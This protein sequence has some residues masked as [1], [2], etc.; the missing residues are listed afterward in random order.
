MKWVREHLQ[1]DGTET[2]STEDLLAFTLMGGREQKQAVGVVQKLLDRYGIRWLRNASVDELHHTAG[3]TVAQASRMKAV[4]ELTSRFAMMES[5]AAR[6][7]IRC[8]EDAAMLLR[9]LMAHLDHEE[10][11]VLVLDAKNYVVANILLYIGTVDTTS[12]R[13][14]EIFRPAVVRNCPK[15]IAAHNHPSSDPGASPEDLA[16]TKRLQE[17][18]KLL[19]VE[20]L[21]H[22]IIGNPTYVSLMAQLQ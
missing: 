19:E 21:D 6:I 10:F 12:L 16:V 20:L 13:I 15:V 9:P 18:G 17:A 4:C 2:L 11:R 7:Q 22:I 1:S 5:G 14:A 3:L 8:A